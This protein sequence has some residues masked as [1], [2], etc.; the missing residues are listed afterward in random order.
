MTVDD[1]FKNDQSQEGDDNSYWRSY[2]ES[3]AHAMDVHRGRRNLVGKHGPGEKY[4]ANQR[5]DESKEQ[6]KKTLD[7]YIFDR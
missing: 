5:L 3:E 6:Q 1:D 2:F 7:G 4:E